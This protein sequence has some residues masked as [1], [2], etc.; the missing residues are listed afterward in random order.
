MSRMSP[1]EIN[2]RMG[3]IQKPLKR[4]GKINTLSVC[5][6]VKNEEAN[7]RAAI[8]SFLPF[9]DEIIVNDTG[10]T[11]KTIEI[12]KT[13]PVK[14]IENF[15]EGDFAK[16]RNQSIQAASSSWI[17]WMDADDRVDENQA[18]AFRKLK[19]APLDRCFGFQVIN[20]QAGMSMGTRFMQVRM[21]PNHPQLRFERKVH[22]QVI[23]NIARLGLHAFYTETEILHTGYEDP[24]LKKQKAQ[25][26]ID[27]LVGDPDRESDPILP[28]QEGDSFAILE[29]WE[30]A[31]ASYRFAYEMPNSKQKN[32]DAWSEIPN[33]IGRCYMNWG[34]YEEAIPWFEIGLEN[35]SRKIE[36][37]FYL[38]ELYFKTNQDEKAKKWLKIAIAKER[39]FSSV[40]SQYDV[41]KSYSYHYYTQLL[42]REKE[43]EKAIEVGEQWEREWP[44]I[45][46]SK[47]VQG[48]SHL[49]VGNFE[50]AVQKLQEGL[51]SNPKAE[52]T[53]WE[54][55]WIAM[56]KAN[57]SS[58]EVNAWKQLYQESF[59]MQPELKKQG[60]LSICMIVKNEEAVLANCLTSI[61]KFGA[62]LIV[63]DT[64]STDS[65]VKIAEQFGAKVIQSTWSGDFS[66]ARNE[67]IS[68]ATGEYV[69]WL[70]ADDVVPK[71]TME[72]LSKLLQTK[73]K[74]AFALSI[75]NTTDNGGTGAAFYQV[76]I[77]PNLRGVCFE[78]R[79]HE[80]LSPSLQR[81]GIPVDFHSLEI[82]HTGYV[83]DEIVAQKQKRNLKIMLT[84]LE[85]EPQRKTAVKLYSIAGSYQDLKEF[86]KAQQWYGKAQK[87]SEMVKED[88]HILE[89]SPI[90]IAECKAELG[91]YNDALRIVF[92]SLK[93]YPSNADALRL[94]GQLQEKMGHYS[95]AKEAYLKCLV[96]LEQT[97]VVPV[98]YFQ[99]RFNSLRYLADFYRQSE[100]AELSVFLLKYALSLSNGEPYSVVKVL[101][102]LFELELWDDCELLLEFEKNHFP[103]NDTY[104][105]LGKVKILQ[106][107]AS[108][109]LE[110]LRQGKLL[111]P[112]DIEMAELYEALAEDLGVPI[113]N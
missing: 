57:S 64:G 41:M 8:N 111:Y 21:F 89:M 19:T 13:L 99:L 106:N 77:F 84:E 6:I 110:L 53:A 98:D 71:E 1:E 17:L 95:N 78:G 2:R 107:E 23:F 32:Q 20:T 65:T 87:Q 22:E 83:N 86:E 112:S 72:A 42:V 24:E 11:D 60:L 104:F 34:K 70:D 14:L 26:N 79:V 80:Q 73:P 44:Q 61:Q 88:P 12:L 33:C 37:Y 55:L 69:F 56:D 15:W 113:R 45:V 58:S 85:E 30:E 100:K 81:E 25:R 103:S 9:A 38:G 4:I 109:A 31:I 52:P 82:F 66:K 67:S 27:L 46:E 96:L 63:V 62:E 7:I 97:K 47:L 39:E 75:K 50:K 101:Q 10:S 36:P 49:S 76:R 90:K 94:S 59:G 91:Q 3:S 51:K 40:A 92:E 54:A 35:N 28:M 48:K 43:F 102:A 18:E 16:A 93:L 74:K 29:R 105:H 68:Y 108:Q 5:M